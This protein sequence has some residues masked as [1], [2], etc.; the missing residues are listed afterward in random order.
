M[1]ISRMKDVTE[2]KSGPN[3]VHQSDEGRYRIKS[4]PNDVH[5]SDE[6]RYRRK[7]NS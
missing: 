7:G 2:E 3:D 6:V 5:Q 4:G 1:F